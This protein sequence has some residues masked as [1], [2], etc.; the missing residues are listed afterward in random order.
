MLIDSGT[1]L[2]AATPA[3]LDPLLTAVDPALVA[4]QLHAHGP[5]AILAEAGPWR[6]FRVAG[7]L[8]PELHLELGRLRERTFRE[9]GEGTGRCVDIDAF[10]EHYEH[11]ICWNADVEAIAGA[12]R[13]VRTEDVRA[14]LGVEGLYTHSLFAFGDAFLDAIG[15]ALELGRSFVV[16]EFQGSHALAMLW[17]GI[18]EWL[19]REPEL[20]AMIGGASF[21]RR[22]DD[23]TLGLVVAA[24]EAHHA[25]PPSV[26]LAVRPRTP[27]EPGVRP[28]DE[29]LAPLGTVSALNRRVLE[30]TGSRGLPPLVKNYLMLGARVVGFNVDH[31]FSDVVD[32]LIVVERDRID[33]RRLARFTGTVATDPRAA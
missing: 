22:Y 15:P 32:A 11:L 19:A 24:L 5:E 9:V 8:E 28:S 33:P 26:R 18:G 3:K 17:R 27:F 12:Y 20:R 4:L 2:A 10:D 30:R 31:A 29:T 7:P 13:L 23:A 1:R 16:P 6:V 25:M 14:T 21:D